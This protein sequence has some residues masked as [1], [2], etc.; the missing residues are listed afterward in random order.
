MSRVLLACTASLAIALAACNGRNGDAAEPGAD[1]LAS[2][3]GERA[4]A[5]QGQWV[6]IDGVDFPARMARVGPEIQEAYVFAAKHPEVLQY[7]PCYCGCEQEQPPHQA[8]IDCFVDQIDRS[9]E[10][11]R[12]TIDPMGFG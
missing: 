1:E 4:S 12:V 11:P 6:T 2:A 8:N 10:R 7:M 9:G 3:T 5:A